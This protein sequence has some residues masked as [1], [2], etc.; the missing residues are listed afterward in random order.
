MAELLGYQKVRPTCMWSPASTT[1]VLGPAN[2]RGINISHSKAWAASSRNIWVKNPGE[3]NKYNYDHYFFLSKLLLITFPNNN[4]ICSRELWKHLC[5][6]MKKSYVYDLVLFGFYAI[7]NIISVISLRKF[8][9]PWSLG[10]QTSTRLGNVP[11]PMTLHHDRRAATGDL[12]RDTRF[13]IPDAP[14]FMK[15]ILC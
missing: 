3:K 6:K 15:V 10:K 1:L 8:T 2:A 5:I 14:M 11:C 9:Y 12:T 7:F 13:Q 4:R